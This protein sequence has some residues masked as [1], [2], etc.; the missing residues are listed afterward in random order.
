MKNSL[1]NLW[2]AEVQSSVKL[3][4]KTIYHQCTL[5]RAYFAE[6]IASL[7][8]YEMNY[9]SGKVNMCKFWHVITSVIPVDGDRWEYYRININSVSNVNQLDND[10]WSEFYRSFAYWRCI[11]SGFSGSSVF[12]R[13]VSDSVNV[14]YLDTCV[15]YG[16]QSFCLIIMV[17]NNQ[18]TGFKNALKMENMNYTCYFQTRINI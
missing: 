2:A 14:L 13:I 17:K 4:H 7:M 12:T 11:N 18:T 9:A 3:A 6:I 1:R 10:I 8:N 15:D 16:T 5:I